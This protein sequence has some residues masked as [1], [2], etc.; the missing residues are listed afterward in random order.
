MV[1][2]EGLIA[3]SASR[4]NSYQIKSAKQKLQT[5]QRSYLS[6]SEI[7]RRREHIAATT[8]NP[9]YAS[10]LLERIIDGNDLVGVN[11]LLQGARAARAV[12]RISLRDD[13]GRTVGYGTGF[14]VAPNIV[15]T[16]NH[17]IGS[18][19]EG[20]NA[21]IEFDYEQD[22]FFRDR[23]VHCFRLLPAQCFITDEKLDFTLIGVEAVAEGRTR[24]LDEIPH[25][26]LKG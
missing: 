25:L 10:S 17:V 2:Q 16:N 11:Y 6:K 21:I 3:S 24:T 5:R 12:G 23:P 4:Y 18:D 20:A 19:V 26:R 22:E 13:A 14:L 9:R 15:M 1:V 8:G 7:Q